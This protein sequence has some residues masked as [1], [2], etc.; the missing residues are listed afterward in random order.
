MPIGG[1]VQVQYMNGKY[2]TYIVFKLER[3]KK[4]LCQATFTQIMILI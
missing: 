2:K 4:K 3:K 1:S